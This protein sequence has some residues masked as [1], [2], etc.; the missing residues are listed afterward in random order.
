[1]CLTV[2]C[3]C[4]HTYLAVYTSVQYSICMYTYVYVYYSNSVQ[5]LHNVFYVRK[6]VHLSMQMHTHALAGLHVCCCA[7]I[8][9]VSDAIGAMGLSDG[10]HRLS[11]LQVD[12]CDGKA[13]LEG[14]DTL[15]GR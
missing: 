9:L 2:P 12:V 13:Q 10:I 14:T 3:A 6:Y 7:G 5:I 11:D 8:V 15:A 1:M 4:L